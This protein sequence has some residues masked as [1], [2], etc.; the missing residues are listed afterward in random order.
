MGWGTG[1]VRRRE[2]RGRMK[3]MIEREKREEGRGKGME[4]RSRE[5]TIYVL[6]VPLPWLPDDS[7]RKKP[8]LR[9]KMAL[10]IS[11]ITPDT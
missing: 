4:R 5:R 7:V 11:M 2:G 3:R 6:I 1:E 10:R 8:S 9:R